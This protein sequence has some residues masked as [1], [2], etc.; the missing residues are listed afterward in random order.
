MPKF[1]GDGMGWEEGSMRISEWA[2]ASVRGCPATDEL[3]CWQEHCK[4]RCLLSQS[5]SCWAFPLKLWVTQNLHWQNEAQWCL[6]SQG[7]GTDRQ[8]YQRYQRHHTGILCCSACLLVFWE[9]KKMKSEVSKPDDERKLFSIIKWGSNCERGVLHWWLCNKI[10][11]KIL[12]WLKPSELSGK[13]SPK[14]TYTANISKL[15]LTITGRSLGVISAHAQ[16]TSP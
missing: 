11:E 8:T 5:Q 2:V 1:P 4:W 9:K 12:C 10:T 15:V 6:H 16:K 13:N 14:Y 3:C 7:D